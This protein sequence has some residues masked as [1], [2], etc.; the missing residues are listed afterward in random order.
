MFVAEAFE[1]SGSGS[2]SSIFLIEFI[3]EDIVIG[4]FVV[5]WAVFCLFSRLETTEL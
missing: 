2:I 1:I 5:V 3:E 4:R